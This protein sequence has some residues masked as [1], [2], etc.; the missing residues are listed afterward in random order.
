MTTVAHLCLGTASWN[1][2]ATYN[3]RVPPDDDE[4]R[5]I[6][7]V[8]EAGGIRW[9]DSA[10]AYGNVEQRLVAVE[11]WKRF[12]I[13]SKIKTTS[14]KFPACCPA[15]VLNHLGPDDPVGMPIW[16]REEGLVG[17]SAYT[18]AQAVAALDSGE[19][20]VLQV[21]WNSGDRPAAIVK[22][23]IVD[24]WEH[25]RDRAY[26]DGVL[27]FG[28]QPFARG[29]LAPPWPYARETFEKALITNPRGWCVV[30]VETAAQLK[31]LLWWREA[32]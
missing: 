17:V 14:F 10:V 20:Q 11:A 26:A 5:R 1:Q 22:G 2:E 18:V 13:V 19:L 24:G 31:E 9:I 12:K 25:V 29:N 4:M 15:A 23:E 7:D 6:L 28:R 8:A 3:G 21:P 30:G 27:F 16:P 32:L